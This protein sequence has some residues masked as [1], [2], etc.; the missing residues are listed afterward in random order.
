MDSKRTEEKQFEHEFKDDY[1]KSKYRISTYIP[2]T[3]VEVNKIKA[4]SLK[5]NEKR[6]NA[7][8]LL[9]ERYSEGMKKEI[10]TERI[11]T[12]CVINPSIC[13]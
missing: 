3:R 5:K 12:H 7:Y 2:G 9:W 13:Q 4:Y 11:L 10:R 1:M 6:G 8:A